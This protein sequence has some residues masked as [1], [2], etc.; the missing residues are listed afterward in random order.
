[1]VTLT[2]AEQVK[3]I[4]SRKGMTIKQLAEEIEAVTGMKMSR[5]NLTQRLGRD[6]FQEK[7]MRMIAEILG[8]G[9]YLS[10][11]EP[12]GEVTEEK[13]VKVESTV[14]P[15]VEP[16]VEKIVEKVVEKVVIEQSVAPTVNKI[17]KVVPISR[18][19]GVSEEVKK[20]VRELTVGEL[21]K[22]TDVAPDKEKGEINP[23]TGYEYK[24]NS[25]R[26]H[27][28]RIGYVQVYDR[29]DH[30]WSEMTEWAF[31]GYQE[32]QKMELGKAYE[33]PTYLD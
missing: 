20:N 6:N 8:C 14:E 9:F 16:I 24:S 19:K 2:F 4:L 32:K 26:V 23:Y 1:M 33:E 22:P 3:L 27:P 5:Q 29:K 25:V 28:T 13:A 10:I 12:M 21:T 7:D 18:S 31:L 11:I 17:E 30:K 15:I